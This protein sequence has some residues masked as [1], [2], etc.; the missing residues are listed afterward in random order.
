MNIMLVYGI[1]CS[2]SD[3]FSI[4]VQANADYYTDY[5]L[6][7]FPVYT[8]PL[9]LDSHGSLTPEFWD[10]VGRI[11][12]TP[13]QTRVMDFEQPYIT[14]TEAAVVASLQESYPSLQ[15]EWYYVPKT[16]S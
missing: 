16:H 12:G 6:L 1:R 2:P 7:V 5:S 3:L 11:V 8:K 10:T 15:P 14:E 4:R 13:A 9:C